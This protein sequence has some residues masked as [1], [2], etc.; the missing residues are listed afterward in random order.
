M[1]TE[2]EAG[3]CR[4]TPTVAEGNTAN[5]LMV[6]EIFLSLPGDETF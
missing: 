4:H 5:P 3:L 2:S 1:E 6:G